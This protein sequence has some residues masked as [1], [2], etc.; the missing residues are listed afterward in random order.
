MEESTEKSVDVPKKRSR[1]KKVDLKTLTVKVRVLKKNLPTSKGRFQPE[2]I[3]ELP[4]MEV[5]RLSK[6]LERL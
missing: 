6:F 3:V 5:R 1:K 2:D 4:E